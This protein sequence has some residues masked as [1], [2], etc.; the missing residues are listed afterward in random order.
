MIKSGAI[1]ILFTL[2]AVVAIWTVRTEP[3]R[4]HCDTMDGPVITAAKKALE[5]NNV[6]LVLIWVKSDGEGEVKKSFARAIE[7]RKLAANREAADRAFFETLVRVHRAAE[8]AGYEGLKP[9]GSETNPAVRAAD[10][11]V[12]DG[13]VGPV[14]D[15]L[16]KTVKEKINDAFSDMIAKKGYAANDVPA[17][18]DYAS[19][20]VRYVHHVE[21]AYNAIIGAAGHGEAGGHGHEIVHDLLP[22]LGLAAL[23][24]LVAGAGLMAAIL[25]GISRK[26]RA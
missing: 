12:E 13:R 4:A 1:K 9:A 11:A 7:A 26:P 24:G 8:G 10:K 16:V 18:R 14:I 22:Y 17:G 25:R 6:D 19:A 15:L 2:A 23:A 5:T 21:G 3:A 20:Y